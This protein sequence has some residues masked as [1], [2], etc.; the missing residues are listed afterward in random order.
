MSQ[1]HTSSINQE[2]SAQKSK[3]LELVKK[4]GKVL[5]KDVRELM[6]VDYNEFCRLASELRNEDKIQGSKLLGKN[7][8]TVKKD[9][10]SCDTNNEV[11]LSR[12]ESQILALLRKLGAKNNYIDYNTIVK[13]KPDNMIDK[14]VNEALNSLLDKDFIFEEN[15]SYILDQNL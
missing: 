4:N 14:H 13:N 15:M 8:L 11:M 2:C 5:V 7:A 3:L 6:D 9:C 1:S 10:D 12:K